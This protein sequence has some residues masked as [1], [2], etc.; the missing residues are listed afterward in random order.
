[1]Q[2]Y[3]YTLVC[4]LLCFIYMFSRLVVSQPYSSSPLDSQRTLEHKWKARWIPLKDEVRPVQLLVLPSRFPLL[5][6]GAEIP[7]GPSLLVARPFPVPPESVSGCFNVVTKTCWFR[8]THRV[9]MDQPPPP[10]DRDRTNCL[11]RV[12]FCL[13]WSEW[14][15]VLW[16]V[17]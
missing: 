15:D 9:L 7:S 16:R 12:C 4:V 3:Y 14:V 17:H 1:M 6:A 5:C 13:G 11:V 2:H 8:S 10:P